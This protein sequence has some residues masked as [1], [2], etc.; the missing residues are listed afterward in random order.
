[1]REHWRGVLR[2]TLAGAP[3]MSDAAPEQEVVPDTCSLH[4]S[5]SVCVRVRGSAWRFWN[6]SVKIYQLWLEPGGF[7]H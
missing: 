3:G 2:G 5:L 7:L 1:M 4:P 6:L